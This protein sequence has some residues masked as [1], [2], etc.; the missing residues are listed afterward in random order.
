MRLESGTDSSLTRATGPDLP[1]WPIMTLLWGL[2]LWWMFGLMP[3]Y[4]AIMAVP[5]TALLIRKGRVA[6]LPGTAPWLAFIAWMLPCALMLDSF[7]RTLG[8]SLRFSQF[9]GVALALLYLVNCPAVTP[10][11][12]LTGLTVT[13]IFII[14]S[15][16]LGILWPDGTLTFTVGR[17]LPS[18]ITSNEYVSDLVFPRFSEVQ[19]PWGAQ[20][21]FIRPSAPFAYTNGWGA[22]V[23][24]LTPVAIAAA[25]ERGTRKAI[26]LVG[27]GLLA[28]VPPAVA[29]TNRGLFVGLIAVVAYVAIRLTLR[30]RLTGLA[31]LT[32]LS[33]VAVI[34]LAQ[35]GLIG[36]IANREQTVDTASGRGN[37]YQEAF[38]RALQSPLLGYGAPRPSFTSEIAVGTQGALWNTLF[39]FGF[40][41]LALLGWFLIG[42]VI[43][44][45]QAPS[46]SA[47]WLHAAVVGTIV[48]AV[49]YGLDRHWIS[50]C[51]V[52]GLLLREK[53][54]PTT[55][56][57]GEG[58][59]APHDEVAHAR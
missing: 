42:S 15:G 46:T 28:A 4:L 29:S 6:I 40:V 49:Y 18:G 7:G 58:A 48:M 57:F 47:L 34:V 2:P 59:P 23:V 3:F 37:L 50:I 53:Y 20:E 33:A 30:G 13:W 19:Q 51:L 10:R 36:A 8:F 56:Y 12:L 32:G 9:V 43:R 45:R 25:L 14:A 54:T 31:W 27:L 26:V 16:Y 1:A 5:M 35:A 11:K 38:E 55:T 22:A 44:T 17:L 41:G 24:L 39:C 52:I 21:P